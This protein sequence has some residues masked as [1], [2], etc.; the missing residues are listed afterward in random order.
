[1][2]WGKKDHLGKLRGWL[3]GEKLRGVERGLMVLRGCVN[4]EGVLTGCMLVG[5]VNISNDVMKG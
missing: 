3:R 2:H 1:M 4:R 5:C